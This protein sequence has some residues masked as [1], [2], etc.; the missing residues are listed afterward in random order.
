MSRFGNFWTALAEAYESYEE[1]MKKREE[2]KAELRK[3]FEDTSDRKTYTRG[4]VITAMAEQE[5]SSW[6]MER[7]LE[8]ITTP[9]R[10]EAAVGLIRTGNYDY[11]GVCRIIEN[12]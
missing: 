8:K 3:E 6:D 5:W 11:W 2:E 10:A 7:V 12:L 1:D 4:T 9:E